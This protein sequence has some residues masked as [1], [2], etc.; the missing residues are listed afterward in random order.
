MLDIVRR[1]TVF[2]GGVR[3]P[4]TGGD[5]VPQSFLR[6]VLEERDINV[7]QG[8]RRKPWPESGLEL[9]E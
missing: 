5:P 8:L 3:V 6:Y 7:R 1:F 4:V 2:D 9:I